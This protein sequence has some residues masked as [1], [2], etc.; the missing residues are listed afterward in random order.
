MYF[1]DFSFDLKPYSVI[2]EGISV[3]QYSGLENTEDRK[4]YIHFSLPCDIQEGD[5]LKCNNTS[6]LVTKIDFDTYNGENALLKAFVVE[7]F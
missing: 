7:E 6:F 3:H 1:T 5:L 2:R 4:A